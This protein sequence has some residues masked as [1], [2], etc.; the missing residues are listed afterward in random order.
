MNAQNNSHPRFLR[1]LIAGVIVFVVL[2]TIATIGL[3]WWIGRK[4][5]ESVAPPN[6]AMANFSP[7][8]F[9]PAT[10]DGL[11]QTSANSWSVKGGRAFMNV[12]RKDD[13]SLEVRF[14]YPFKDFVSPETI[15]LVNARWG[16]GEVAKLAGALDITPEQLAALKA[17]SPATDM[18]VPAPDR[19]QLRAL[20]EDYLAAA[21][22]GPAE[23]ALV[24]A[25]ADLDSRYH[26]STRERVDGI[27]AKVK[28]IFN[29]EQL[30][31]L[32]ERFA[33]QKVRAP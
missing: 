5:A 15:A 10:S 24:E 22:K 18:P 23:K 17:I 8:T 32:S 31:A 7:K 29:E 3:V 11:H 2:S 19:E 28:A 16:H 25:V 14:V 12:R 9:S 21:D 33:P 6:S 30:A 4:P 1:W 26:D 27:A 20:F 13:D